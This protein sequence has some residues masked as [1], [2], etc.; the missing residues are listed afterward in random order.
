[1]KLGLIGCGK[2]GG[3]LLEGVI[4]AK[5]VKPADIAVVDAYAPAAAALKAKHRG[6]KVCSSAAEVS[7]ASGVVILAVKPKDMEALLRSVAPNGSKK[8]QTA[9]RLHRRRHHPLAPPDLAGRCQTRHP[10]HAQHARP[11][12]LGLF[13]LY[14]GSGGDGCRCEDRPA[15]FRRGGLGG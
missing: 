4:K 14:A 7:Q 11:D 9:L 6:L 1:M 2:M 5:L 8:S 3:A 12:R 13:R 10:C 15:D